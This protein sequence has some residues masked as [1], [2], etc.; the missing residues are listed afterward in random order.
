MSQIEIKRGDT[1]L[2]DCVVQGRS[3]PMDIAGWQIECW[4]RTASGQFF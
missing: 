1:L 3:G 4:L 2:L